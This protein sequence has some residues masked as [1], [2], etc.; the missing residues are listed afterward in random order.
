MNLTCWI[1][2]N[3][4]LSSHKFLDFAQ[5]LK[6]A[7]QEKG[8]NVKLYKNN[9]LLSCLQTN[10]HSLIQ[11]ELTDLPDYVIFTDKDIYLA[12]QLENKGIRLFNKADT[13]AISDDKILTYQQL[14]NHSINIP[15]TI[16]APK[17]FTNESSIDDNYLLTIS[18]HLSFPLIIKE[19]FGSFGEQVYLIN[20][21]T[22]MKEKVNE[23]SRKPF[24]FQ[25]FIKSSFGKDLRLQVVGNKVVTAMMRTSTDDFRANVTT[26]GQMEPYEPTEKEKQIAVCATK[27]LNADFAGV[28]LLFGD[29]GEPIVCEVNS[30]A[31][32]RNLLT[33]TGINSAPYII[34]HIEQELGET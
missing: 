16:I 17:I 31:H 15:K 26:G 11:N 8:H 10:K 28:D 32:I 7:A 14:A 19:A 23:I 1:I 12:K 4:S 27:A 9:H 21:F 20:S 30:N 33:C 18:E 6:H 24:I 22:E 2:Y 3:G 29:N 5:M 25:Q 34:D 13:I